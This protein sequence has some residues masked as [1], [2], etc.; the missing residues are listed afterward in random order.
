[1][2]VW[3]VIGIWALIALLFV[4]VDV[5]VAVNEWQ[6]RIHIGKWKSR[7]EWQKAILKKA[8]SWMNNAPTVR[9]TAQ[10]RLVLLDMLFGQYRSKTIQRWQEAGLVMGLEK[11]DVG[12]YAN[13][14]Q[15]MFLSNEIMPEDLLLAYALK[16]QGLLEK[17]IEEA[18]L[19][20][21]QSYKDTGTLC[22]RPW[23]SNIRFVDT[24]G[25]ILPF[26][27]ACG[28]DD[29]V[30]RQLEEY[31]AALLEGIY[32]A[33]AYDTDKKL[34][35]GVYDWARGIG[36]YILALI[37]TAD[38]PGNDRRI[39]RLSEALLKHQRSDGSFS[40]FV[41]NQRERMESSGTVLIGLLFLTA[42]KF[43]NEVKFLDAA[44]RAEKALMMATR[45]DGALDYCQGDTYG[46]GYY[47]HI[48]SIMPFAQGL[49]V[50]LTKQLDS[51]IVKD[52]NKA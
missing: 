40:C 34:P 33:H 10:N 7:E 8:V 38:M 9:K 4:S 3:Y 5:Y 21:F 18:I 15:Q 43:S 48:F 37:E 2:I 14:Y 30:K 44:K 25:M 52:E 29:L 31:D 24:L 16:Q 20:K 51:L 22:Y 49:L 17:R 12:K 46:I 28:W 19:A 23:V 27:H 13:S 50:R 11:K 41:F 47:S 45:R 39:V 35:L 1:M 26:F 36:W 32:P 42:Y 6:S